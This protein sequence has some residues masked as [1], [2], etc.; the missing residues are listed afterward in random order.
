[1]L[2]WATAHTAITD[3]IDGSDGRVADYLAQLNSRA[4]IDQLP[5]TMLQES[6]AT[7]PAT[8]HDD[9]VTIGVNGTADRAFLETIDGLNA[10]IEE[11]YTEEVQLRQTVVDR[12]ETVVREPRDPEPEWD[13]VAERE[14]EDVSVSRRSATSPT[15]DGPWHVFEFHPRSV[16]RKVTITRI[17]NTS[18]G[19]VTTREVREQSGD[20]AVILA[21]RH[22]GGP[23]PH[24]PFQ[25][26]HEQG[27]TL[28]GP[29]LVS[30]E[31]QARQQL[32][33]PRSIKS[34]AV[35]AV[36]ANGRTTTTSVTGDRPDGIYEYVYDDIAALRE[37]VRDISFS[38]TRGKL[39][40]YQVNPG[41]RL[42]EELR[43]EWDDLA[44]VPPNYVATPSR[45]ERNARITYL[46]AVLDRLEQRARSHDEGREKINDG[47]DDEGMRSLGEM[48]ADY[49]NQGSTATAVPLDLP[50]RVE[51]APAYL[52]LGKLDGETVRSLPPDEQTHPLV[53]RN[54]NAFT[55][56]HG[57]V[58]SGLVSRFLGP[59]RVQ[60]RAAVQT[61]RAV[62]ESDASL[63]GPQVDGDA[64]EADLDE[65][66]RAL[67]RQAN[68]QLLSLHGVD[69][70]DDS[71]VVPRAMS[72]WDGTLA[73]ADAW[74]NGSAV[75]AIQREAEQRYDLTATQSDELWVRLK[76]GT[77]AAFDSG[78]V[79]PPK[80][81]VNA[82]SDRLRT[83]SRDLAT[84]AVSR[85]IEN[86]T[87][88]VLAGTL[89][90]SLDRLPAGLPLA[91]PVFPW[92]TTINYWQV[93]VRGEYTRFVV[94]VPRGTPDT[95]GARFRYVRNGGTATLDVDSDGT[96]ETLG[97][98]GRVRVRTHTS[99]AIAVPPGLRGVGDVDGVMD[100]RSAGWPDPG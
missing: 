71:Y 34:L 60:F 9:T 81:T 50:L 78:G 11:T 83:A 40:T 97:Q 23:A 57:D 22:D 69:A 65:S 72:Q 66:L 47:L 67:R 19:V 10:T 99:V 15:L 59:E 41:Q 29:N 93:Q 76:A 37:E 32:I 5:A 27:G 24:R 25:T 63:D 38:T 12:T 8:A 16:T 84:T 89:E 86:G 31:G 17:W 95:P 30:I 3:M 26:V 100:E 46:Q 18:D 51:T 85:V 7:T 80:P 88:R 45:A 52:T 92:V 39:A 98:D 73:R 28:D 49:E 64:L 4:P 54:I 79:K 56:P 75:A 90:E 74:L 2:Q 87:E 44:A 6:G 55:V 20:V 14:T 13:F 82:T 70:F 58:A 48:E 77:A 1:M 35:E 42:A 94:S 43:K 33:G 53:A 68:I 91:P 61:L 96:A 21:G 36:V 62:Q